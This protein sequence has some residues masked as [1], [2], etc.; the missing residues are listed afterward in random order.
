MAELS[1][2]VQEKIAKI[3]EMKG[4]GAQE[5]TDTIEN[6]VDSQRI[7]MRKLMQW[8]RNKDLGWSMRHIPVKLLGLKDKE[9]L[10][11]TGEKIKSHL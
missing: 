4:N 10:E 1:K 3:K 2:G 6:T 8:N 5:W 7:E 9:S 11:Q